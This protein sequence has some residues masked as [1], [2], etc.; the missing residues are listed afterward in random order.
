MKSLFLFED[1]CK[2]VRRVEENCVNLSA[3]CSKERPKTYLLKI[4]YRICTS[5]R[6]LTSRPYT[7]GV[8]AYSADFSISVRGRA[9]PGKRY[10][11]SSALFFCP[12]VSANIAE[13]LKY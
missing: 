11:D 2:S 8:C 3:Y 5:D 13:E 9:K 1:F 10:G 4:S 12:K 7:L 6:E